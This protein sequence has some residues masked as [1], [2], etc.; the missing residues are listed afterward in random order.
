MGHKIV[1][2]KV[3]TLECAKLEIKLKHKKTVFYDV[4][5][6]FSLVGERWTGISLVW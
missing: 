5:F 6:L 4:I 1:T 3:R 2:G